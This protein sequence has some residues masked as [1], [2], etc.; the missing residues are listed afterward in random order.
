M[1]RGG[2][3]GPRTVFEGTHGFYRAFAPSAAPDFA[4]LL[5]GLG[6]KW[7]I[8]TIAF[9]P[10]ACGTMTQPFIDC[11]ISL[12]QKGVRAEDIAEIVCQVAEGTVH[13]LWEPL[14]AKRNP[15]TPYAAKF[16][17]PF[18]IAIGFIDGKAG[19]AQFTEARTSDP[20]VRALAE[21]IRYEI[22]PSDPYPASF[23]GHLRAALKNGEV[24]EVRQDH[25]RGGV[26]APLTAAE[27]EAKC[28]DNALYGGWPQERAAALA[29]LSRAVFASPDMPT[30]QGLRG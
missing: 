16:S 18:C 15:P 14:E 27:I 8:E 24:I 11:A 7:V 13:R 5:D 9:K 10:Y 12:A 29:G 17:T 1:A 26:Q 19:F 23:T 3:L 21:K 2:F 22:N 30:L 6:E 25:M 28:V 4:L 20:A